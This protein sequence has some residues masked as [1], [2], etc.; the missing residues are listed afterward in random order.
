[1]D[2]D[3]QIAFIIDANGTVTTINIS[4]GSGRTYD[5]PGGG[6]AVAYTPSGDFTIERSIDGIRE[7]ALGSL[8]RPHYFH[9]GW[10][11]HGSPNVPAYP[12]SHGCIRTSNYDQDFLF[13]I[14]AID[15]P[16]VIYGTSLGDPGQ[17]EAGF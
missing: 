12:A 14:V 13:P 16:V 11:I 6:T 10:A 1:V 17:G 7:A 3:R 2:L 4:S 15:D 9:E 8:Y 5:Q